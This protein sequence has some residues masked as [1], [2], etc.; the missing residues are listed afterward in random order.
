MLDPLSTLT[1]AMR[2]YLGMA[3]KETLVSNELESLR[4]ILTRR[5]GCSE[6]EADELIAGAKAAVAEGEDP[7][8]VL[9]DHFGLEPDYVWELLG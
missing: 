8:E 9:S 4:S 1:A 7:E 3:A 6:E 2:S 5:D